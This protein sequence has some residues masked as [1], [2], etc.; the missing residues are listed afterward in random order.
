MAKQART[1]YLVSCVSKKK[2]V[3]APARDLYTSAWF[4]KARAYV[5]RSGST[6]F[7]LSAQHGLVRPEKIMAPYEQTLNAMSRREREAWAARVISQLKAALPA[8]D[9]IVVLAGVRY[10]EF[11]MAYLRQQARRV[12]VPMARLGI[13]KQLRY[14]SKVRAP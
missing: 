14:L 9:R 13:G 5:E 12:E 3:R 2:A 1:V 7:I 6:W 10:R 8:T 11:I 4:I